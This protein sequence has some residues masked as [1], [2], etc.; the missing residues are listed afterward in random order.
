MRRLVLP[1]SLALLA[2]AVPLR[3]VDG[4]WRVLSPDGGSVIDLAFQPGNPQVLYATVQGGVFKSTDGGVTWV[5]AG[6]GLDPRSQTSNL[7]VDPVLPATVYVAQDSGVFKTVDG[8]LSWRNTG[9][10]AVYRIAGHP[11]VSGTVFA[12]TEQGL[13]RTSDGGTTWRRLRRGLPSSYRAT[14]IVFDPSSDL[15]LYASLQDIDFG[16][17]GLFRST[18]GGVTWRPLHGGPLEDQRIFALAVDRR[19]P[20][21]LYAGTATALYKSTDGGQKWRPTGLHSNGIVWAVSVH[22]RRSEL[23]Y[24][25]TETGLFRSRDGGATWSRLSAGLPQP[26]AVAAFAFSPSSAKT[27][28][29]GVST[30]FERGGVF[31]S[32]NE[33]N[34]W[35]FSSRGLSA[36]FIDT[37][38]VDPQDPGTLW[39]IGNEVPFK[40]TDRGRTWVRVRPD[41]GAGDVQATGLAVDPRDGSTVYILLPGGDLR[42]TRDGGQTWEIAGNPGVSPHGH[43]TL[44]IDPQSPAMLYAAGVGIA[45]STDRGTT[46]TSLTGEPADM[47]F[48]DLVLS[49][50]SSATLYGSGGGGSGG[51]RVVR[52]LDGGATWTRIQQDLPIDRISLTDLAVDPLISTSVYGLLEGTIYKTADGGAHWSVFSDTFRERPLHRIAASP[53]TS[54]LLYAGVWFDN[55]YQ[56]QE[57]HG[58]WEPLGKSSFGTVYSALAVDPTDPCRIYAGTTNRGLLA[59]TRSG[60]N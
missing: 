38:A 7:A 31:K 27:L 33:G 2:S 36:L 15:R 9:G 40:S 13:W 6:A 8:G 46:W 44:A 39:V 30:P 24:A 32:G 52:T 59:F 57:G 43:A 41:P 19:S 3:A 25:G 35:T 60:C 18:D 14:M 11:R 28:Y 54:G 49:P 48:F 34:S 5:W 47:V 4:D 50:A 56:I 12:A 37:I 51:P 17:G 42:R 55:V 1:L 22:P 16:T 20:E 29:A 23:V 26:G 53:S 45:K 58:T 21:T 10:S